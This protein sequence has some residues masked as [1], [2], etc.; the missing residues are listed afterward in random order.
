VI[1]KIRIHLTYAN[2]MATIAVFIA[3]GGAGY[4][5]T[6]VGSKDIRNNSIRSKDV[7]NNT[8]RS[9]DIRN[10]NLRGKDIR[11]N[12][13]SAREIRESSFRSVPRATRA[14]TA[15][16]LTGN[17]AEDLR[18]KCPAGTVLAAGAC[19]ETVPRAAALH[20]VAAGD[21]GR[22]N[23]RLPIFG[24][25]L[26]YFQTQPHN[27]GVG[28]E[29][30]GSVFRGSDPPGDLLVVVMTSETGASPEYVRAGFAGDERPYR[31]V[32]PPLN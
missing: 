21:C 18:V 19:F 3:L 17:T 26:G 11:P 23:R 28:G 15:D 7:R 22:E 13:L 6:K 31:C 8:L 27:L 14:D 25:L 5:A 4:A 10:N 2:V 1:R 12:T 29:L 32:A 20:N 16:T 30:T 24:E 9:K